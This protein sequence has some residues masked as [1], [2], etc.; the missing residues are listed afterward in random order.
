[1]E[2]MVCSPPRRPVIL[3][4]SR[5]SNRE[6]GAYYEDRKWESHKEKNTQGV[7]LKNQQQIFNTPA[8]MLTVNPLLVSYLLFFGL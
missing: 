8:N 2:R 6:E 5:N 7:T 3:W 1:M 4:S